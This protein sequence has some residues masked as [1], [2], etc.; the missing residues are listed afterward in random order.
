MA[1]GGPWMIDRRVRRSIPIVL[2]LLVVLVGLLLVATDHWR[3][4]ATAMGAAT[5]LAA[6]LRLVL[7][8]GWVGVLAVRS[9]VFDVV[10]LLAMTGLLV[11]LVW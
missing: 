1:L 6:G 4:G 2:V 8:E 9:R 5:G 10:F 7:P 11:A 3:K